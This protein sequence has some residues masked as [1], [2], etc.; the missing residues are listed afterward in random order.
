MKSLVDDSG[1]KLAKNSVSLS[2]VM[3]QGLISNGPLASTV[4]ALTAAA[5]YSLGALPLAYIIG[6]I[7]VF[8]WLN[9]PLQFSKKMANASGMQYFVS[10]G[11][12]GI[13]GYLAGVAYALYYI[14]LPATN[15]VLFA[16]IVTSVF[17]Q[18]GIAYP[19]W[20]WIPL[21]LFFVLPSAILTYVGIKSSLNY[22]AVTAIIE[23]IMLLFLSAVILFHPGV[24][25]TTAVYNPHLASG[26]MGGLMIGS[27]V[28]SFGMA[29]STAAVYLGGEAKAPLTTIRKS[30]FLSGA[31][32]VLSFILVSYA[33]TV[34]WGYTKM[35]SFSSASIPGLL[36]VHRFLGTAMEI[37]FGVLV[38]NSLIGMNVASNIVVS[39]LFLSFGRAG[40]LP[41]SMAQVHPVHKTPHRA[42]VLTT[43][44]IAA[45]ALVAGM[46]WGASTAFLVLIMLATMSMFMG[47]ILGNIALPI[48]Y[49]KQKTLQWVGHLV[50]PMVSLILI[51]F[52]VFFT[53]F[54]ITTPLI[55]APVLTLLVMAASAIQYSVKQKA[56]RRPDM[57]AL[58]DEEEEEW[59]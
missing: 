10:K 14:A 15:S 4:A 29:G 47:H 32:L 51:L 41:R 40:F 34:G 49:A 33:L 52:G 5:S 37:V 54:P 58:E 28:A 12:G 3:A 6:G 22:G 24:H 1:H 7:M 16:V 35:G 55:Y 11:M 25:S 38:M 50:V 26:G 23:I 59:A 36:I 21:A 17:Q 20:I 57:T 46:I 27:L 45:M 8:L 2:H 31:I 48:Y 53:F 13:W 43:I 39:R 42:V 18:F 44:I 30:L 56:T 9:T 19:A